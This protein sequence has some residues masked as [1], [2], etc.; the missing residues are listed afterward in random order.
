[1]SRGPLLLEL[2]RVPSHKIQK[3]TLTRSVNLH[4]AD[5]LAQVG[6]G[7]H[8]DISFLDLQSLEQRSSFAKPHH[9]T[10]PGPDRLL[11]G[12]LESCSSYVLVATTHQRLWM[13]DANY[14]SP[15]MYSLML[16]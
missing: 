1:M 7:F 11:A 13:V 10:L 2:S 6:G 15:G 8:H 3:L 5:A 9:E 14:I 16:L 4:L 12:L